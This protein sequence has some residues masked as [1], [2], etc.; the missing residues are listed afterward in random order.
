MLHVIDNNS[1]ASGDVL[2]AMF[3]AREHV[4]VDLLKWDVPVIG[5]TF[6]IDE[7]DDC[8][9]AYLVLTNAS[10]AHLASARLLKTVR[11]H[12]L[13]TLFPALCEGAVPRA[14]DTREITRFCLD[15][16]L[17]AHMRRSARDRLISGLAAYALGKGVRRYTAVAEQAW[18][19]QIEAF[20]WTC[21]T[22]GAVQRHAGADIA[23]LLIDIDAETPGRLAATG[24]W[25]APDHLPLGRTA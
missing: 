8:H 22:L 9:A 24:I 19:K 3:E 23:A 25:N 14:H 21:R 6:E 4:F 17:K 11:P 12:I 2:R 10:G 20:G 7:F 1:G 15:R 5:G 18:L 16:R 13:G